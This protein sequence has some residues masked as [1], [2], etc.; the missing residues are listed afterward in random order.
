MPWVHRDGETNPQT[1]EYDRPRLNNTVRAVATLGLMAYNQ[2][3]G[4]HAARAVEHLRGWFIDPITRMNP[5]LRFAPFIPGQNEGSWHGI[6]KISVVVESYFFDAVNLLHRQGALDKAGWLW[7]GGVVAPAGRGA[8]GA[9]F[10]RVDGGPGAS[11]LS[12]P[13]LTPTAPWALTHPSSGSV[14]CSVKKITGVS[15]TRSGAVT[16]R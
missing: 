16:R 6:M 4:P 8:E 7:G 14:D 10:G 2:E 15:R 12:A 5:H 1:K 11:F 9:G 13:A 3:G